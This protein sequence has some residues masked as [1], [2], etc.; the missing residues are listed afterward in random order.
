MPA[1]LTKE[2]AHEFLDSHPGWL[3]LTTIGPDG[4]PHTV[5]IGYFRL[6]DEVYAGGRSTTQRAMNV[7]RNSKVSALIE[8]GD[9]M[10]NIKGLLIQGD[11]DL[12]TDPAET[13]ELMRGAAKHRGT[14]E[15]QLPTEPR[16]G[17]AYIRITPKNYISWDYS[18][19]N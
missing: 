2:E 4:Y 9:S 11:A 5:P 19:E 8:S 6:G 1:K 16:P 15:D 10:Q 17:V 18:R 7:E 13:L 3:I 12:V 14:P